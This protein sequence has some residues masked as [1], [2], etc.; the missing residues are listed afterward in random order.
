MVHSFYFGKFLYNALSGNFVK[1][2]TVMTFVQRYTLSIGIG[3]KEIR[4]DLPCAPKALFF[5]E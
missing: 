4:F 2:F 5:V 1:G 3:G